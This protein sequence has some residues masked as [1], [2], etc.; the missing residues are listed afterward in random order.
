MFRARGTVCSTGDH[1]GGAV[2]GPGLRHPYRGVS[3]CDPHCVSGERI[4]PEAL[5]L[6]RRYGVEQVEVLR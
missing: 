1:T 2:I 5:E 4:G 3:A 6:F